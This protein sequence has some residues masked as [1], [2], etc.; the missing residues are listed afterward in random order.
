MVDGMDELTLLVNEAP[1][2]LDR[3]IADH[4][5]GWSRSLVQRLLREGRVLVNG[6]VAKAS[7]VPSPG[8]LITMALAPSAEEAPVAP[9]TV[10]PRFAI[11]YE[12]DDLLVVD[13]PA[14]VVVHPGAGHQGGTLVDALLAYRP[15]LARADVDPQRLGIVHRLDRDTSGLMVVAAHRSAQLALQAMFRARQVHK[16]YLA[17]LRGHLTPERG[18]IEAAIGRSSKDRQ[19]MAIRQEGGRPARTE[20]TVREFLGGA[21]FVE[22][23][24]LTGRTHQLRVHFGSIGHPIIG[25]RTYGRGTEKLSPLVTAPRQFLHAWRLAFAHPTSGAELSFVSPLPHDLAEILEFLR[26]QSAA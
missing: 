26:S 25:D 19:K 11:V 1:V 24:P 22:A 5:T 12:D 3:Y 18:A 7:D 20:Y 6:R 4:H 13:K 14:G 23:M 15:D 9:P 10:I 8:D 17:L 16:V 2:R 21:T